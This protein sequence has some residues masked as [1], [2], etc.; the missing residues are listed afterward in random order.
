[1]KQIMH[2]VDCLICTP[3]NSTGSHL[4]SHFRAIMALDHGR[5]CVENKFLENK[6][7]RIF[8]FDKFT[9]ENLANKSGC[10][11]IN[12]LYLLYITSEVK[13]YY[14]ALFLSYRPPDLRQL[15]VSFTIFPDCTRLI[16]FIQ[17]SGPSKH[18][19][20]FSETVQK[21]LKSPTK[22]AKKF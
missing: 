16:P 13:E 3:K 14:E 4:R 21:I 2:R 10:V 19:C 8:T 18:V 20:A 15:A 17:Y 1:M 7:G 22:F 9:L 5:L 12:L 6:S 11:Q